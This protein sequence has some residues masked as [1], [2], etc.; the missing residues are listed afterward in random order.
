MLNAPAS[1]P[2]MP[3]STMTAGATP[4]PGNPH[5]QGQV[6]DEPV[7][8]AKHNGA[9]DRIGSCLVAAHGIGQDARLER[10]QATT[11]LLRG[12]SKPG[13]QF[14]PSLVTRF[15]VIVPLPRRETKGR[16]ARGYGSVGHSEPC[17]RPRKVET[18]SAMKFEFGVLR[19]ATARSLRGSTPSY[20]PRVERRDSMAA[21]VGITPAQAARF[22]SANHRQRDGFV[23]VADNH[24]VGHL[25]LEP[26]APGAEEVAIAVGDRLQHHGVGILLLAA[27]MASA[28]LRGIQRLVAWVL[29]GNSAMRW[30]SDYERALGST[31]LAGEPGAL[32]VGGSAVSECRHRGLS[33]ALP[34]QRFSQRSVA[35]ESSVPH[36]PCQLRPIGAKCQ[37]EADRPA[38]EVTS[39]P[40]LGCIRTID[41][42]PCES[43][44]RPRPLPAS[45][46]PA[47]LRARRRGDA[48]GRCST[49]WRA[50]RELDDV[51]VIHLHTEGPGAAP[52]ARRWP[53]T[54]ATARCSSAPTRGAV[55]EGRAD[56]IPVFL[57]DVPELFAERHA[58]ARRG[59]DQRHR[60]MR[61]ASARS[62][63]RVDATLAAVA[64]ATMVI[65]QLNRVDAA[66]AR[67]RV[68][69]R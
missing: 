9:Q 68:H 10:E 63:R 33:M 30:L 13:H 20:R 28:R 24:I 27:A 56:Y 51:G 22:A 45:A 7:V 11:R 4:G 65:A 48:V 41:S 12:A 6:A 3:A 64:S 15:H 60:R 40:R 42:A 66:H 18:W 44:A 57:S 59:A 36:C 43:S 1:R 52:G 39:G 14:R 35:A 32:R 53:G 17:L 25:V 23:A 46:R 62:G 37:V 67:R 47:A 29:P 61:T 55:N 19:G 49:R 34:R 38:T 58:A 69:P 16:M 5:H 54:S 21:L 31:H 26:D 2:A 50:R 8:G